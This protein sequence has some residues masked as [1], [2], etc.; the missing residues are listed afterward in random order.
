MRRALLGGLLLLSAAIG[1]SAQAP[2]QPAAQPPATDIYLMPLSR[3]G[4]SIVVGAAVNVTHRD[5]YDNQPW[6]TADSRSILYTARSDGQ[7]DIWR[8]DLRTRATRRLTK[9]PESEYSPQVMPGGRRFSAIRVERDSTQRLW[10]FAMDGSDP[11]LVLRELKPVGYHLWL[12]KDRL[13][14]Y[15]LGT[16]TTLHLVSADGRRDTV[17]ARDVGRAL[18]PMPGNVHFSFTQR[19][20]LHRLR[21]MGAYRLAE[22]PFPQP[23]AV[24]PEDDEYHAWTPEGA[25]LSASAGSIVRWNA[26]TGEDAEWL[27]VAAIPGVRNISRLAVSP[28]GRWLAFV[29][30]PT[31]P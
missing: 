6:F 29:A 31:A 7:S 14:A 2:T 24:L 25:L 27:P 9:T 26:R 12:A 8:Y 1:S 4:D 11:R 23:L 16:P 17:V 21:V 30:E 22:D 20:T 10:S 13:A 19:D 3:L 15:V 28:E 18:Q 5:G